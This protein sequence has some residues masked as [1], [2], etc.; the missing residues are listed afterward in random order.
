MDLEDTF[1]FVEGPLKLIW[2]ETLEIRGECEE[3]VNLTF[4]G[5]FLR[6]SIF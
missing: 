3:G 2:E 4:I 6:G 5:D 1:N